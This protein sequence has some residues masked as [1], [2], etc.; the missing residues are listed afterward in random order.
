MFA[1]DLSCINRLI[2]FVVD[3]FVWYGKVT[4]ESCVRNILFGGCV[5][6]SLGL[7]EVVD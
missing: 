3:S 7:G 4:A 6:F 1:V 2:F 5:F